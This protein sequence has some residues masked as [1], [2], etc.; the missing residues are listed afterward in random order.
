MAGKG[1]RLDDVQGEAGKA[2]WVLACFGQAGRCTAGLAVIGRVGRGLAGLG[3]QGGARQ[4]RLGMARK[5]GARFCLSRQAGQGKARQFTELI[6]RKGMD[7]Q[8]KDWN[9]EA[10]KVCIG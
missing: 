8:G 9:G 3:R 7:G 10:G 6:G 2:V 4:G 1:R 5:V